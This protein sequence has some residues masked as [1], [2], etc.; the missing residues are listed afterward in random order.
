MLFIIFPPAISYKYKN[1]LICYTLP[2]RHCLS[3]IIYP[4]S[5][6]FTQTSVYLILIEG[7]GSSCSWL[8]YF[9]GVRKG[10]M[11]HQ[12]ENTACKITF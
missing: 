8:C 6:G 10:G 5:K 4:S 1:C 3:S 9:W 12:G 11:S 7:D 2:H